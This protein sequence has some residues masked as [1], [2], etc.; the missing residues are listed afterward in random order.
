[1]LRMLCKC[2]YCMLIFYDISKSCEECE[3]LLTIKFE[4]NDDEH[5]LYLAYPKMGFDDGF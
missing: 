4:L 5:L 3:D 1:M 2:N